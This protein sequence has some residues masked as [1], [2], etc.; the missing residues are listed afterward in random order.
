MRCRMLRIFWRNWKIIFLS[1]RIN[2]IKKWF[3]RHFHSRKNI[4]FPN[5]QPRTRFI[6]HRKKKTQ[7]PYLAIR[8]CTEPLRKWLQPSYQWFCLTPRLKMFVF[9]RA[10]PFSNREK[11]PRILCPRRRQN[12]KMSLRA[13][14]LSPEGPKTWPINGNSIF[15]SGNSCC[16][17][18]NPCF[19]EFEF[20]IENRD[21]GD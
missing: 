19:F 12:Q 17:N 3:V 8:S 13:K 2:P 5:F 6:F 21:C 11:N 9:L 4:R 16:D 20:Q 7:K 15:V 10:N 1:A 14:H 18:W